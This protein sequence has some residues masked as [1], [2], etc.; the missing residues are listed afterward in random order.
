MS[1]KKRTGSN[2]LN[3]MLPQIQDSREQKEEEKEDKKSSR[4][5]EES[6]KAVVDD[7]KEQGDDAAERNGVSII[8]IPKKIKTEEYRR[9]TH[10][11]RADQIKELDKLHKQ[12]GRDKSELV[13]M[14]IDILIEQAK[15]E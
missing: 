12:S 7:S 4:E 10:Y 11:F 14:A 9:M 13:R 3:E 6:V 1:D 15:I 8:T 2:P 5:A